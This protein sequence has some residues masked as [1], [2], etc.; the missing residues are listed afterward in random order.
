M[1]TSANHCERSLYHV[2]KWKTFS[3]LEEA[4]IKE[5]RYA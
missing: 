2:A 3:G 4:V 5:K 1:T